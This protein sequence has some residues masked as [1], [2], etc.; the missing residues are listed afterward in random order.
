MDG[1]KRLIVLLTVS[2]T[3]AGS[4]TQGKDAPERTAGLPGVSMRL[5]AL[6][7]T[8]KVI[9][10]RC[11]VRND[12]E[13]DIWLRHGGAAL[14]LDTGDQTLVLLR[15]MNIPRHGDVYANPMS[16]PYD[17]LPAGHSQA[18]TL[19]VNLPT[20]VCETFLNRGFIKLADRDTLGRGLVTPE[21][22][23]AMVATRLA[24]EIG[25]YTTEFL[26]SAPRRRSPSLDHW[27]V[28]FSESGNQVTVTDFPPPGGLWLHERAVRMTIEGASIPYGNWLDFK[29]PKQDPVPGIRGLPSM[30]FLFRN[31]M[32]SE[33]PEPEPTPAKLMEALFYDFALGL[34]E[35]RYTQR[36]FAIDEELFDEKAQAVADAYIQL[37]HGKLSSRDLTARLD[38][39]ATQP[40]RRRLLTGLERRADAVREKPKEPAAE[41]D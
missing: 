18:E 15:R 37:A 32:D 30:G 24:F 4:E 28:R 20:R 36:L 26:N 12:S 38:V 22:R 41:P 10:L 23:A 1:L 29:R 11:E 8:S 6:K 40:Q 2:L 34:E 35:Y 7:I 9:E 14:W 31:K 33:E 5:G 19:A 25:F 17:R 27:G 13:Q 3:I 21:D 16:V 39:I